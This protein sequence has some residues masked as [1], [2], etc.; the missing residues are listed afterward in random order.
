MN[1]KGLDYNTKRE[2]LLLPEYGR[3][4]Q[5]MVDYAIGL[6]AR[7]ERTACA[8]TIV[9][10]MATK[11]PNAAESN[12]GFRAL[13]DHLYL[14]GRGQLDIDWPCDVSEA[15]KITQKPRPMPI[16]KN[17]VKLRHYGHL[18]EECFDILKTMP[19]GAEKDKLV[20]LTANQMKRDLATW[21]RGT[22]D[23]E[24]VADDLARYTD[25]RVQLDINNM[26]LDRVQESAA[27]MN[28]NGNRVQK[29]AKKRKK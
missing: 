13:W 26:Q 4:I 15:E 2:T 27:L 14:M 28:V 22:M 11:M 3:E 20:W 6:P 12:D 1:I 18:V 5:R 19:E 8:N 21:G 24:R 9:R 16:S 10:M 23:D 17:H 29:Q 7:E 25:G